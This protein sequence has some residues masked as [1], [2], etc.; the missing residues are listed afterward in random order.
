MKKILPLLLLLL[1]PIVS[2]A[3]DKTHIRYAT[4]NIRYDNADDAAKGRGWSTRKARIVQFVCDN[5]L[6]II[7][8]QE[9][10]HNQVQDLAQRLPQYGMVGV[11]R[12]DGK[13]A[14]EYAPIWYRTD[15]YQAL[16][17]GN[18]WL[19]ET[20][21]LPGS[22]GWDAVCVRIATWA[23]LKEITTGRVF[24]AVNTHFDHVGTTARRES[25]LLIIEKIKE[26]VGEQSAILTGDFNVTDADEA[27][28]TIT[29]NRF[30][31][32]DALKY[33]R[34]H[35]GPRYTFHDFCQIPSTEATKIDF[36]F[37]TSGIQVLHTHISS[38]RR[39]YLMSDHNF[40]FADLRF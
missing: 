39:D 2:T 28:T 24:M 30:V 34:N 19:S 29:T 11:G 7:G 38:E 40:H 22:M 35:E 15:K 36:I 9:V 16:D 26:I 31:L 27:Y 13:T 18:F 32:R 3:K 8:M 20:P 6:D 5:R 21:D 33:S 25:A 14:G 17:S 10:L 23:K 1:I 12:D 4:M 37:C